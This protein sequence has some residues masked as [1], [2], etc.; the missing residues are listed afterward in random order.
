MS[1]N[2]CY[3]TV[4]LEKTLENPLDS[5]EIKPSILKEINLD[6]SLEGL[7]LKLKLEHFGHFDTKSWL[8]GKDP[9]AGKDWGQKEKGATEDEMVGWHHWLNGHEFEQTQGDSEGKRNL[10][11]CSS[12]G[13][14]EFEMTQ[15]LKDNITPW[16]QIRNDNFLPCNLMEQA[17]SLYIIP[18]A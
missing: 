11:S 5:K 12:W 17:A 7:M 9:D 4:M 6:Y 14:K 15:W 10:A 16:K 3:W 18:F 8:T 2:W 13:H 1:N